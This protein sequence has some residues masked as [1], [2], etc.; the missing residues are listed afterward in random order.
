MP[1]PEWEE[2]RAALGMKKEA[3]FLVDPAWFLLSPF[4]AVYPRPNHFRFFAYFRERPCE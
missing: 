2:L 1:Q 3:P 4:I